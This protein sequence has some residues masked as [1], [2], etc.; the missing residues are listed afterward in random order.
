MDHLHF[1]PED[2]EARAE[3]LSQDLFLGLV[4]STKK[5]QRGPERALRSQKSDSDSGGSYGACCVPDTFLELFLHFPRPPLYKVDVV[6]SLPPSFGGGS[7]A[8]GPL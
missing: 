7:G 6:F 5:C 2:A 8:G 1:T 4:F 3:H